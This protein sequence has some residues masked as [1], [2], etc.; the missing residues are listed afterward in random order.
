MLFDTEAL[1]LQACDVMTPGVVTIS[2]GATLDDAVDAMAGHRIHAV[3]VVGTH[4]G[5]PLGWITSRG[6]LG[7]VGRSGD[8]PAT[9][10][11]TEQVKA[12]E[13]TAP[14]RSAIYALALPGT[15]RLLV[16]RR[17][18]PLAEGVITDYDLSVKAARLSRHQA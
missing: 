18:S 11:I 14:L 15:T 5:T 4:T 10:A 1:A 12:I 3:L 6:L 7:F 9:E 13:P 17:D 8:T 2:D 16:R